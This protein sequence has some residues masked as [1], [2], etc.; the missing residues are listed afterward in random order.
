[1][2]KIYYRRYK[3]RVNSGE[4]TLDEAIELATEEVPVRWRDAVVAL[5]EADKEEEID[6]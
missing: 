4:I 3:E 5:L 2:A 6:G 1:M